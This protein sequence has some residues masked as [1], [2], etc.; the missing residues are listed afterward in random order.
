LLFGDPDAT[1]IDSKPGKTNQDDRRQ[2]NQRKHLAAITSEKPEQPPTSAH[3]TAS[4]D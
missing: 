3:S 1:E 4:D 2:D